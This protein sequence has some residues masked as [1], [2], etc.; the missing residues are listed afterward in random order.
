MREAF[1]LYFRLLGISVRGQ[2]QYRASFWLQTF[3]HMLATG[4]EFLGVGALFARFGSLRGWTLPEVALFYGMVNIAFALA[5]GIGRG[6]DTFPNLVKRG[7]F[8]RL[9]LRPHSTALQVAGQDLQLMRLGRLLQGLAVLLWAALA[10]KIAW[11]PVRL[12]LLLLTISGGACLFYGLFVL[13]ATLAFW[14]IESLEIMNTVTYGGIE[15]AQYPMTIYAPWFRRFFT[16]VVPLL[17]ISTL[18]GEALLGRNDLHLAPALAALAPLVGVLFLLVTLRVWKLGV[19][20][21]TSTGS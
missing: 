4:V 19:R 13:Q 10:L 14:T 3:G 15:T 11:T 16:F 17:C 12:L 18:P 1:R 20:H 9:L 2:M 7:D 21:Y 8:D 6:F 5:E